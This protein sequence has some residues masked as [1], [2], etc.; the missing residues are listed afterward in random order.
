MGKENGLKVLVI[1]RG[2]REHALVWKISQS[3][4][5]KEV[6]CAPGNAGIS[7]IATTVDI[8]ENNIEALIQFAKNNQIDITV[9]GSEAPLISGI[10]DAFKAAGLKAYGPTKDAAQ[11]EGSKSFA[12]QLM[13]KYN[14]PTAAY[15]IF[16]LKE[17]AIEYVKS[18]KTPI[19]IKADG[20]AAGKGVIIPY[21]HDEAFQ[22]IEH[23]MEEKALGEAGNQ[24]VIE[25][26][27]EGK[28][29]SLMA[30]VDGETVVPMITAQ[31]H[32]A[33]YDN[34]QGPNTGG[35]GAYAPVPF[36]TDRDLKQ[37]VEKILVPT[38]KAMVAEGR[39]FTGILYAGLMLTAQ[40]P[41]VI[42]FNARFGDP[43]AQVVLPLLKTDIID[44]IIASFE[45]RLHEVPII[46]SHQSALAVVLVSGGY[47]GKYQTGFEING[48]SSFKKK[49]PRNLIFHAGTSYQ[50]DKVFTAS[51][52][53]LA[54][55]AIG[56]DLQSCREQVYSNI[57]KINFNGMYY[58]KDIGNKALNYL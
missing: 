27:L 42:E 56:D 28:E 21:T 17:E 15:E 40:G 46:W 26:Y 36:V 13:K 25:E 51:G 9:V 7:E 5:V 29:I 50:K 10:V 44:I 55:T 45:Q 41:K 34:D 49:D 58:R 16:D 4:K 22:A 38:A 20:L 31:D 3:P 18:Q 48:L 47:P 37:A 8:T 57:T 1:G 14:I 24:I 43:E 6:Y 52:R 53:V 12:K 39:S 32:K 33:A 54:V 35:M 30:F 2:G 19:V 11:I 23:I